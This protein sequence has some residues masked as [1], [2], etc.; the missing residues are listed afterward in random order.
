M[1]VVGIAVATV[2]VVPLH[3]ARADLLGG[4][5]DI[6]EDVVD[7]AEPTLD[8]AVD[9]GTDLIDDS[10]GS[11]G[12]ATDDLADDLT[13][14]VA[15][16]SDALADVVDDTSD[17]LTDTVNDIAEPIFGTEEETTTIVTTSTT[18]PGPTTTAPAAT[19]S[20]TTATA[21]QPSEP[22]GGDG[23]AVDDD[24]VA[25]V[26]G[27]S[28]GAGSVAEADRAER[29]MADSLT[30]LSAAG[31]ITDVAVLEPIS[32]VPSADAS[33]YGRLLEWLADA[34]STVRALL[35]GPLLA[36]EILIRALVSAGSG[37][38]APISLLGAYLI[39]IMWEARGPDR[40]VLPA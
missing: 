21:A 30:V 29:G 15:E 10:F 2:M 27:P 38:V 31:G 26:A 14:A 24:S 18:V 35:A 40:A 33:I 4:L 32:I 28:D 39:R 1:T 8:D 12:L 20:P 9:S 37:L 13:D 5:T 36:L 16:T 22:I 11:T 25:M 34:G 19:T 7:D 3:S 23:D 17:G 6:V